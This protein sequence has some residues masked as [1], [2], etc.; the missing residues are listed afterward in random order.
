MILRSFRFAIPSISL[1][2]LTPIPIINPNR[3]LSFAIRSNEFT[4]SGIPLAPSSV[5]IPPFPLYYVIR[6]GADP[7]ARL[8]PDPSYQILLPLIPIVDRYPCLCVA[9]ARC[10]GSFEQGQGRGGVL[11][12][13]DVLGVERYRWRV[14]YWI[15]M[16][17][18]RSALSADTTDSWL[19]CW[20]PVRHFVLDNAAPIDGPGECLPQCRRS[21]S[22]YPRLYHI[23]LWVPSISSYTPLSYSSDFIYIYQGVK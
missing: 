22:R 7:I 12:L 13:L 6:N 5:K 9:D 16:D 1:V 3:L 15:Q 20:W 10:H 18:Q 2:I 19:Y 17:R 11:S 14:W 8:F 4:N 21:G 23:R